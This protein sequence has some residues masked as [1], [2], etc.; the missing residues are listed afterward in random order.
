MLVLSGID[1]GLLL[2]SNSFTYHGFLVK[3]SGTASII[4]RSSK[5]L[6]ISLK[7]VVCLLL[8]EVLIRFSRS[9]SFVL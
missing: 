5:T 4:L 9:L 8:E 3:I 1:N 2:N 7:Q 6:M